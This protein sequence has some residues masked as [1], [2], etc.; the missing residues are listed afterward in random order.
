MPFSASIKSRASLVAALALSLVFSIQ[1]Y[2]QDASQLVGTWKYVEQSVTEVAS[3]KVSKPFGEKPSGYITYTKGG[4]LMF[5][6]IGEG[7]QKPP[8]R[9]PMPTA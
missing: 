6:L 7:R 3:G 9:S 1:A 2:A 8:C 5:V 4:R